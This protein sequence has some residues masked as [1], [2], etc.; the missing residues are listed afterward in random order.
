MPTIWITSDMIHCHNTVRIFDFAHRFVCGHIVQDCHPRSVDQSEWGIHSHLRREYHLHALADSVTK[1]RERLPYASSGLTPWEMAGA[2]TAK[3]LV[4]ASYATMWS[5][6]TGL[7]PPYRRCLEFCL[8]HTCLSC[9]NQ[10][11]VNVPCLP[12]CSTK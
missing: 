6:R 10:S 4:L 7:D 12:S 9:A 3:F 11:G 5:I 1:I 2:N 8:I